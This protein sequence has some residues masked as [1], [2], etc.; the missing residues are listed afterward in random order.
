MGKEIKIN[1]WPTQQGF[2]IKGKEIKIP[3]NA[4]YGQFSNLFF[5]FLIYHIIF[6]QQHSTLCSDS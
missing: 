2:D 3:T 1:A 6:I 4:Y 5:S